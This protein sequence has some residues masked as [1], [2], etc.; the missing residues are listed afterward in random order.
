MSEENVE[1]IRRGMDAL[2][3]RDP[4]AF[5]ACVHPDVVWETIGMPEVQGIHRGRAQVREW[6][7]KTSF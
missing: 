5:I 4:D 6:F 1:C 2:N 3:R 7:E